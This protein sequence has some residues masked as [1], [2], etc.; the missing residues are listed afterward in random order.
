M[1]LREKKGLQKKAVRAVTESIQ[2]KIGQ[3]NGGHLILESPKGSTVFQT[4]TGFGGLR[5][6]LQRRVCLPGKRSSLRW[7]FG[8]SSRISILGRMEI[9]LLSMTTRKSNIQLKNDDP[10]HFFKLNACPN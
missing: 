2:K 7:K 6:V 5:K 10:T 1:S 9:A 4:V 3:K 8:K